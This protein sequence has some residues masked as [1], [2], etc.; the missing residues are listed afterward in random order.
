MRAAGLKQSFARVG[1]VC[2]CLDVRN[3]TRSAFK[4]IKVG[5]VPKSRRCSSE[6]HKLSAAWAMR[7][8]WRV[9]TRVFVAHGRKR[10]LNRYVVRSRPTAALAHQCGNGE[11]TNEQK[12]WNR[13]CVFGDDRH[14]DD[15]PRGWTCI[16][17]LYAWRSGSMPKWCCVLRGNRR[18]HRA[19][20]PH[21]KRPL[22]RFFRKWDTNKAMRR[23]QPCA[24]LS[25][26]DQASL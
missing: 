17:K 6:Q 14:R 11:L 20:R 19:T 21:I 5:Q 22:G 24:I 10:S 9:F 1:R 3:A 23:G 12:N 25:R 15:L 16:G 2:R 26:S 8:P 7:R 18:G 13:I 4:D